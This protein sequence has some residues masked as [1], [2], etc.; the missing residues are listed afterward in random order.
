M[1]GGAVSLYSGVGYHVVC[2]YTRIRIMA[3]TGQHHLR[4]AART[5]DHL[6]LA[7]LLQPLCRR[8]NCVRVVNDVSVLREMNVRSAVTRTIDLVG[9]TSSCSLNWL[10]LLAFCVLPLCR[11]H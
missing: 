5:F 2:T 9:I 11:R 10:S 3:V 8:Q 4:F 7:R 1:L 6:A